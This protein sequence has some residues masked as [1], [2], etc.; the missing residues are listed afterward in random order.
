M[1]NLIRTRVLRRSRWT[2]SIR[3]LTGLFVL[4]M[5][6]CIGDDK[7][8]LQV[9][10][11]YSF[12]IV[13][14]SGQT[15]RMDMLQEM[16]IYMKTA[17]TGSILQADVLKAMFANNGAP[18]GVEALDN[19]GKQLRDK[20]FFP[21]QGYFES[22]MEAIADASTS[23]LPA[24]N[25]QAGLISTGTSTYLMDANG[26]EPLQIIE[27]GLMGAVFYY[28]AVA[29]YLSEEQMNV[30]NS[31][32]DP[33]EGTTM[34]HHWDEAFGYSAF[35]VDF[36]SPYPQEN[37]RFWAKYSNERDLV[38]NSNDKLSLAFRTG[39]AAIGAKEYAIRDE[40]IALIRQHWEEVCA[41]TVIHYLNEAI[42]QIG[43]DAVRNHVLSEALAFGQ[44][45]TYN[46][47][48]R[49]SL[50][51]LENFKALLGSNFYNV[52]LDN[53]V[54]ARNLIAE[55]YDMQTIVSSL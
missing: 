8:I 28:Q 26:V 20:C 9:P 30:D 54:N 19:S 18:F 24:S 35:P 3:L 6:S 25:G 34:Q 51:A 13:N 4:T 15:L 33:E 10:E 44:N 31:T 1:Q 14:Y 5:S 29:F 52:T 43:N 17:T 36:E 55:T 21:D 45:L 46:P 12:E 22:W 38:L 49:I 42:A 37:L 41:A 40:Q 47:T 48:R 2:S 50:D 7:L 32:I 16:V 27:K 39:R 11:T 23:T 53:L